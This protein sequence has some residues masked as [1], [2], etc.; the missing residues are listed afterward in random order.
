MSNLSLSSR[1]VAGQPRLSVAGMD[2]RWCGSDMRLEQIMPHP[3][4]NVINCSFVCRCGARDSGV[5][6]SGGFV[7]D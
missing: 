2:C 7:D 1:P 6:S 3:F 4:S 5:F